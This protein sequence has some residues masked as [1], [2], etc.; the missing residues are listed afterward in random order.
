MLK[1]ITT[2][3]HKVRRPLMQCRRFSDIQT[4][5]WF[6]FPRQR[7]GN[8]Y[9]VNWSLVEDGVTPV[10]DAF[11]NAELSTLTKK[12]GSKVQNGKVE[13][14]KP[15]FFG[16]FILQESGDH[17]SHDE[18]SMLFKEQQMHLESGISLYVEDAGIGAYNNIRNGVRVIA[19]DPA[20]ALIARNLLIPTPPRDV[21][22]R[23]RFKGWNFDPRWVEVKPVW[24]GSGYDLPKNLP[25]VARP[26]ERPIVAF[27]GGTSKAVAVQFVENS[28]EIVGVN[29][30]IGGAAPVR[31]MIEVIGHANTVLVNQQQPSSVALASTVLVKGADTVVIL[32]AND[33]I[34]EAAATAGL[35]YGAYH[36]IL[37]PD[38]V[39]AMWNG[40]LGSSKMLTATSSKTPVVS[41]NDK[42]TITLE[43]NNVVFPPKHI[44][45]YDK[46]ASKS[47]LSIDEAL[48][49][50]ID[51]TDE[52]KEEA[53]KALFKTATISIIGQVSD[54]N[55]IF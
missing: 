2:V 39:T 34:V 33:D 20:L 44:I 51:L 47:K 9:A 38:G 28:N 4:D 32:N 36:N 23:A 42:V 14:P 18:F 41:V 5:E 53:I 45:F 10:G 37:T 26:G 40:Y 25:Q 55:G 46:G 6:L 31:A 3:L 29:I 21:N 22:H 49:R 48:K 52:S 7:E 54:L 11:R 24:N 8:I 50:V 1:K 13:L 43:P 17:I 16:D 27:V 30:I 15:L 19:E 12:I 35:L